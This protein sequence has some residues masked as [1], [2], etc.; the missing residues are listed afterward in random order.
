MKINDI[1]VK[2]ET[3][4]VWSWRIVVAWCII[5]FMHICWGLVEVIKSLH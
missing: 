5:V 3:L 2:D 4:R 1:K